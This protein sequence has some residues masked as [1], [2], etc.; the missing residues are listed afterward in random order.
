MFSVAPDSD[1]TIFLLSLALQ[2]YHGQGK[3]SKFYFSPEPLLKH[4]IL[5]SV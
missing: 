3:A 5:N 4:W 2:L 1:N